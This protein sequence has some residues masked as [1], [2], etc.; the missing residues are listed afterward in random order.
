[1]TFANRDRSIDLFAISR[2]DV[3][4]YGLTENI[5]VDNQLCSTMGNCLDI[6]GKPEEGTGFDFD[7]IVRDEVLRWRHRTEPAGGADHSQLV[8]RLARIGYIDEAHNQI[9][10]SHLQFLCGRKPR[11]D[12]TREK[13]QFSA[14]LTPLSAGCLDPCGQVVPAPV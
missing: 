6:A 11:E 5:D 8:D 13:D 10:L 2:L 4:G 12:I 7:E 14:H 3:Y 1:M 9:G